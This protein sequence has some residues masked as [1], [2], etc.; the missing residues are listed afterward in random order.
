M[1]KPITND[2]LKTDILFIPL[3]P[4][5]E[6]SHQGHYFAANEIFWK[7]LKEAQLI[8]THY[9]KIGYKNLK[10]KDAFLIKIE[11]RYVD[12]VVFKESSKNYNNLVFSISD[13]ASDIVCSD[14]LKV[15]VTNKHIQDLLQLLKEKSPKYAVLMHAKVKDKF[16]FSFRN[17]VINKFNEDE[18]EK[19]S[20]KRIGFNR[21]NPK[22][23]IDWGPFGKV[24]F[25]LDTSFF[26]IPFP[27]TQH[28][29]LEQNI[30][31][32]KQFREFI[33]DIKKS[34]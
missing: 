25:G 26:C 13:L 28:S 12:T 34:N 17:D 21:I 16:L 24:I 5:E 18:F 4:A 6:S 8:N 1:L 22:L 30:L 10:G 27:S 11:G 29:T 20:D 15:R 14:S 19:W 9:T 2:E 33:D 3:N 31:Y 7:S 32:W 23:G